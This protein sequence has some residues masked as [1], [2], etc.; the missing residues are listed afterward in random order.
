MFKPRWMFIRNQ[1]SATWLLVVMP[2]LLLCVQA[3]AQQHLNIMSYNI[4]L[5]TTADGQDAW[6]NRK[7]WV[8]DQV[9]FY[10]VHLL[11]VQ[12]ALP[13]QIDD[14]AAGLPG[15]K[16]VGAGRDDGKRKGEF[17]AIFYD[18]TR[19]AL[20][21]SATFWLSEHPADTGVKGWDAALPRVATWAGFRD[22]TS[23]KPFFHFN[24]HFDHVGVQARANSAGLLLN[25]ASRMAAGKPVIIT[26]DFNVRPE[27]EPYSIMTNP[28][29]PLHVTDAKTVSKNPHF[30]PY[31]TFNG[32]KIEANN[33]NR[34][35]YIFIKGN[36]DVL[37]H[38]TLAHVW[39]GRF[40]SDHFPVFARVIIK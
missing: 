21:T 19:L 35:D 20:L 26:G 27:E 34:I 15:Y 29:N 18:T 8:Q 25:E 17:S 36:I 16:W 38:A 37:Q 32:F 10:Q 1:Q 4:R 5:N 6:P 12:E 7:Q 33:P 31:A 23:G 9:Q 39:D 30:G 28:A 11:G 14:L 22:R 40:A 24:T 13:G 2:L 3:N